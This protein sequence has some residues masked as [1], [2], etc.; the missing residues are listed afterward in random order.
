MPIKPRA[1]T[2]L[3][4]PPDWG[5]SQNPYIGAVDLS[6]SSAGTRIRKKVGGKAKVEVR[7]KLRELHKETD[8]RPPAGAAGH[9]GISPSVTGQTQLGHQC[10]RWRGLASAEFAFT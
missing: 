2:R 7:D 10:L 9:G 5:A 1:P 4:H 6:F 8:A 3:Q